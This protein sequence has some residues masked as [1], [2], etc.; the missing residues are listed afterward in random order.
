MPHWLIYF[1]RF[2]CLFCALAT[3]FNS[4]FQ[5]CNARRD[6]W[7]IFFFSI[8]F[9]ILF[10]GHQCLDF[11]LLIRWSYTVTLDKSVY[12]IRSLQYIIIKSL[13]W[14]IFINSYIAAKICI[15]NCGSLCDAFKWHPIITTIIITG[16]IHVISTDMGLAEDLTPLPQ[17]GW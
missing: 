12:S 6:L 1:T 16:I 13:W 2:V 15:F 10:I 17:V 11:F 5:Q 7:L 14:G 3:I 4:N 9:A 8:F